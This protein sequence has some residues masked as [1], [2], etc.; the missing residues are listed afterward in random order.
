MTFRQRQVL[1]ARLGTTVAAVCGVVG[2]V[3]GLAV[4][5]KFSVLGWFN[6][7]LL[8]ALASLILLLNAQSE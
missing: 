8:L 2:F 4:S 7:G 6:A 1:A 3:G 5:P